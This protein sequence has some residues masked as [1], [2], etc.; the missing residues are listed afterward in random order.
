MRKEVSNQQELDAII[1]TAIAENSPIYLIK[2][3]IYNTSKNPVF[4]VET[5]ADI[6][7]VA[8]ESSQPRVVAWG[9]SQPRVVARE[10]SQPRVEAWESSQPRVEARGFVQLSIFGKVIAKLS[11]NC[12]VNIEGVGAKITGGKRTTVKKDTGADWLNYYGVRAKKGIAVLYKAVHYDYSSNH[13]RSF[14]YIPGT[15][16]EASKIDNSE[17]S[18]GLHFCPHPALCKEF[19]NGDKIRYIACPVQVS[20]IMIHPNGLYPSKCKAKR[21]CAPCWEVDEDGNKIA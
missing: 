7:V 5:S 16:P 2:A 11:A 12:H 9:S 8:W 4:I 10:S 3:G 15:K 21:V 13:D 17:C 6:R 14:K 18:E 20:E 19:I 1:D